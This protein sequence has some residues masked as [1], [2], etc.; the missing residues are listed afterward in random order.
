[1]RKP[2]VLALCMAALICWSAGS[3]AQETNWRV[4][5]AEVPFADN[6]IMLLKHMGRIAPPISWDR[7]AEFARIENESDWQSYRAK[8]LRNYRTALGLPFPERTPL[9]ARTVRILDRQSYRIENVLFESQPGI[10]VTANLYVPQNSGPGPWPGILVSCGHSEN[11]KAYEKYHSVCL[12]LVQ[13]GY[14]VLIYDPFGQ[15]ERYQYLTDDGQKILPSPTREHSMSA[16]PLFLMGKHLM[17]LRLWDGIRGIDYL[18]SRS[19]VDTTRIGI[20]GN[21]GGGTVTL[22]LTPLEERIKVA[23]PVG[24]VTGPEMALGSGGIGDGEQNLP[25]LVPFKITHADLMA[26]AWPRPYRLIKESA[27]GVHRSSLRSWAQSRWLYKT[28]GAPEKMSWVESEQPHGFFRE[29]REPT[30]QW[31]GRWFYGR[32][33]DGAEPPLHVEPEDS[34]LVSSSGQILNETGVPLWKWAAQQLDKILPT[35][36]PPRRKD[37]LVAL[38]DTLRGQLKNLLANPS[39]DSPPVAVSLGEVEGQSP[40]VEKLAI[41][42]EDDIYLP[43]LLFKPEGDGKAAAIVLADSRGRSAADIELARSLAAQGYA[44]LAVDLRGYGETEITR[45]S[46]RDRAGGYEAQVLGVMAGVAYDGL[47]L[48]RSIFAMRVFDI[49]RAVEYLRTRE[50]IDPRNIAV[51]GRNSCGLHALYAAAVDPEV[52]GVLAD[53]SLVSWSELA[54]AKLYSWHFQ[55]FLPR[56]LTSHDL[57]QLAGILAPRPVWV[58]NALDAE[59]KLVDRREVRETYRWSMDT[60]DRARA[61]KKFYTGVY[62]DPAELA[63]IMSGW[64]KMAFKR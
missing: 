14:V 59:K 61:G 56:A 4:L 31:F 22:H 34:L 5:P 13:K 35:R 1:M 17:A 19:E 62:N 57:P 55:D 47:K 38:R 50:D 12:G 43:A 24:T 39:P 30:Y 28:L 53:S 51:A 44:V 42:S 21:S 20:T 7:E 6:E 58:F 63:S 18:C 36:K 23:V 49:G 3:R 2:N 29:M 46:N 16:N 37:N 8:L 9:N 15:G 60:F 52:A 11:G 40:V 64:A 48:G 41:Y 54:R 45:R 33:N 26:A 27:G 32:E 10:P 25:R